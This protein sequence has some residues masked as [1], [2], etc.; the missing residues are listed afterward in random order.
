MFKEG[1][2][3]VLLV[4]LV[5]SAVMV[6]YSKYHSRLLFTRIQELEKALDRYEVE[7]GQLQLEMTTLTEHSR[8]ERLAL[9]RRLMHEPAREEIVYLKP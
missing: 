1:L 6:I 4:I 9:T 7:W 2:L 3:F 8:I 5:G